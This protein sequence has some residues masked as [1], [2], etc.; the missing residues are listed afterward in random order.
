V[1]VALTPLDRESVAALAA[2]DRAEIL[3]APNLE[4]VMSLVAEVAEAQLEL[5]QLTLA[6]KPWLAY[7][8]RETGTRRIVGICAFK[9][10]PVDGAVEIAYYTFPDSEGRGFGR[11]MAGALIAIAARHHHV[12]KVVA[13]TAP[14]ENPSVNI[15]R[16]HGF[17]FAGATED[18]EDGT[19]W[20]WER[21]TRE[22]SPERLS[23]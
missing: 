10:P 8:A 20:R 9:A 19:V 4:A 3:D 16:R 21:E 17:I 7:L 23:C 12:A 6:E 22:R 13:H 14:E 1:P 11:A 2:G 18:P 15:L 5:Y